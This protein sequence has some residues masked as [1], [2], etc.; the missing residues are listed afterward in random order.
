MKKFIL[1][2]VAAPALLFSCLKVDRDIERPP[3][4]GGLD[5]YNYVNPSN[6]AALE[7][8]TV[9]MKL[10]TLLSLRDSLDLDYIPLEE[11]TCNDRNMADMLFGKDDVKFT[12][13]GGGRWEIEFVGKNGPEADYRRSG[14]LVVTTGDLLLQDLPGTGSSWTVE[15]KVQ[16]GEPLRYMIITEAGIG[17]NIDLQ[18]TVG[19]NVYSITGGDEPGTWHIECPKVVSYMVNKLPQNSPYWGIS[20]DLRLTGSDLSF[21]GL[22][23]A[24]FELSGSADGNVPNYGSSHDIMMS[25]VIEEPLRCGAACKL[26]NKYVGPYMNGGAVRITLEE[27]T[28]SKYFDKDDF[29]TPTTKWTWGNGSEP[30]SSV[31]TVSYNGY[32]TSS[33]Q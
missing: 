9:C 30:C 5:I 32:T 27:P 22:G 17:M 6:Y 20:Y 8:V 29:P 21:E 4:Q 3:Y 14:V 1:M 24:T 18:S 2:L 16:D 23:K 12:E 19:G 11:L 10:N 25:Y 7:P 31:I 33:G 13:T 28:Y 15:N 26:A